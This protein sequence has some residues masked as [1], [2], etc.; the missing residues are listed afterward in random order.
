MELTENILWLLKQA[1]YF[2]LTSGERR[3]QRATVSARPRSVCCASCPTSPVCPVPISPRRLLISSAGV[4][5]ALTALERRGLVERKQDPQHKRHP[6]GLPHR[7]GTQSWSWPGCVSDAVGRARRGLR[8]AAAADE[9]ETLRELLQPWSSN[10]ARA[11]S[12]SKTT[13]GVTSSLVL[14]DQS[15][16]VDTL[17]ADAGFPRASYAVL[18]PTPT[19]RRR[20]V[21]EEMTIQL[22]RAHHHGALLGGRHLAADGP[23]GGTA[24]PIVVRSRFLRNMYGPPDRRLRPDDQQRRAR[25][26]RGGG[27]LGADLSGSADQP[28]G[29]GGLRVSRVAPGA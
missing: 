28:H 14:D 24:G 17:A 1:F 5:L 4:Q 21:T 11:T 9:Q 13:W 22:D 15:Q 2:S 3:D 25:G 23:D 10:R 18:P 16:V 29:A 7:P 6:A 12:C 27:G 19:D 26:R 8:R 20:G